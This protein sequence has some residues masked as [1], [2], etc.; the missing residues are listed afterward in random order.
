MGTQVYLL[1]QKSFQ[2]NAYITSVP[3]FNFLQNVS[4]PFSFNEKI[5][6][7]LINLLSIDKILFDFEV[8]KHK[9]QLQSFAEFMMT[10]FLI[11][12]GNKRSAQIFTKNFLYSV[13]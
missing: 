11:R 7:S 6:G 8:I 10:W 13:K 4:T 3:L 12:T 5:T 2:N 9:T 1:N